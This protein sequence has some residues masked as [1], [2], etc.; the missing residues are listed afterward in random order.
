MST[1]QTFF[2]FIS[3]AF[4][5]VCPSGLLAT[6]N[7][8]LINNPQTI[9]IKPDNSDQQYKLFVSVP[10]SYNKQP[11]KNYPVLYVL[12]ANGLFVLMTQ[13]YD[14]LRLSNEVPEMIIVGVGYDVLQF[15]DSFAMRVSDLTPSEVPSEE[16][17]LESHFSKDVRSGGAY[18]FLNVMVKDIIPHINENYQ[19]DNT[20]IL[21]GFSLG[22]LFGTYAL[23]N[24][25]NVFT[26]YLIGSPS[27]WWDNGLIFEHERLYA[28]SNSE[29][30]AK[31]FMSVGSLEEE[32]MVTPVKS[33]TRLLYY[34]KYE[35]LQL[36]THIFENER[37]F[38]V[39]PATLSRG[40]R[41]L[42]SD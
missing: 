28:D 7:P 27:L 9:T 6:E 30:N 39:I 38:S 26:H 42:F 21:A 8:S 11:E 18:N 22:G 10:E 15:S 36:F 16:R 25:K 34:R 2:L 3:V 37:H 29:L 17:I 1:K 23:L 33:L 5:F 24:S 35:N 20:R 41:V 4:L 31:V 14:L 32:N 19:S 40:L 13:I 12:D